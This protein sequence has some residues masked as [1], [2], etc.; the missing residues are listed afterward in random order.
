MILMHR[1]LY[2]LQSL[3]KPAAAAAAAAAAVAAGR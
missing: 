1:S 3:A 2:D